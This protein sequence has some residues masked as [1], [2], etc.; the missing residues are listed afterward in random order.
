MPLWSTHALLPCQAR[1]LRMRAGGDVQRLP[2]PACIWQPL[3]PRL[4]SEQGVVCLIRVT[5]RG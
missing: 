4:Q 1:T 2:Y 3:W 5:T